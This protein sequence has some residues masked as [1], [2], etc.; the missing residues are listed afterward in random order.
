MYTKDHYYKVH[1][2]QYNLLEEEEVAEINA[3][4]E[5]SSS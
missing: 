2:S 3:T 1:L 4:A 5:Q